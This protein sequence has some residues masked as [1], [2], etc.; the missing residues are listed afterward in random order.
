MEYF[1]KRLRCPKCGSDSYSKKGWLKNKKQTKPIRQYQCKGCKARFSANS[2][3]TTKL[4][5]KPELNK[6]IMT[7]YC[8]GNTLRGITRILK[9]PYR[10]VV[11]KW[12]FM[13]QQARTAHLKT[14]HSKDIVTKYIQFDEMETFEV[15]RKQPLGIE[16]SIRPKTGQIL[17]AKVCRIPI[18]ALTI[19][20][21]ESVSY[22]LKTNREQAFKDMMLETAKALNEGYSVLSCDGAP[23]TVKLAK[24]MCPKSLIETHVNDYAGM[25]RLNHTCA[26][27]RHHL[28]RLKRKTWATTKKMEFL[29]MHLD[30]FIAYQNGYEI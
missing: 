23:Q 11:R 24:I 21:S 30:L 29:Q 19:A 22:N 20:K 1:L 28:S 9:I 2:L 15:T 27:L 7:L 8:E 12:R 6:K 13:A 26:K 5:K 14:L 16:L 10:T 4:Q 3:K 17:S 25:W 18:R